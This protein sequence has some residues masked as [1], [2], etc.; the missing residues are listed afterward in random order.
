MA[1]LRT[2]F[3]TLARLP[4]VYQ[5]FPT[6]QLLLPVRRFL[7][8]GA[9]PALKAEL[10][11]AAPK[12]SALEVSVPKPTSL[13]NSS[14]SSSTKKPRMKFEKEKLYFVPLGGSSEIGMNMN[15]YHYDGQWIMVDCGSMFADGTTPQGVDIVMADPIFLESRL[16]QLK[17]IIITH[18]HEDHIGAIPFL[19]PRLKCP[20]Y[21]TNFA[22]QLMKKRLDDAK[23]QGPVA[24]R[25]IEPSSTIQVGP[26]D[27]TFQPVTH[28]IPES[29]ALVIK[30]K[31]GTVFH[32]GDWKFD[33]EPLV[34][35]PPD[36]DALAR[37]G[38]EGVL[39]LVGDSTNAC[40]DRPQRSEKEVRD[41]LFKLVGQL[42]PQ[43]MIAASCF[44]SHIARILALIQAARKNGRQPCLMGKSLMTTHEIAVQL[45]YYADLNA[46][47]GLISVEECLKLPPHERFLICTGCQGE[48]NASFS[49]LSEGSHNLVSLGP[50]DV[51]L[52]SSRTI[53]GNE[54]AVDRIQNQF[55][56]RGV[57]LVVDDDEFFTHASGHPYKPEI[58]KLIAL[59]KPKM[60]IPVHGT[61]RHLDDHAKLALECG[62]NETTIPVN[63]GVFQLAPGPLQ[64]VGDVK[65]GYLVLDGNQIRPIE[66]AAVKRREVL[67]TEGI[68]LV[69]IVLDE[70]GNLVVPPTVTVEGLHEDHAA[71]K[72]TA[73]LRQASSVVATAVGRVSNKAEDYALTKAVQP[74]LSALL[75]SFYGKRPTIR[76][77]V[78]RVQIPVSLP[79]GKRKAGTK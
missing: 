39:A 19:W 35:A 69:S 37:I 75:H 59:L 9:E 79:P 40:D 48:Q 28:S 42:A 20:I 62:V 6:P 52:F 10:Q 11:V 8:D 47:N 55:L 41:S 51:V 50:G 64:K 68:C 24:F 14:A 49:R 56:Q 63:G 7:S 23:F 31:A 4:R 12:P 38:D 21:A 73:Q 13:A 22:I 46:T 15:L 30:T 36:Y 2:C 44:S 60:V 72:V 25:P 27:I 29:Q 74:G 65:S 58:R 1:A 57:Q 43:G 33:A 17:A 3:R 45:G 77:H 16:E 71:T 54:S 32:T 34:G 26:F 66:S 67:L 70:A 76:L 61:F 78:I 18:G 5:P 53:P